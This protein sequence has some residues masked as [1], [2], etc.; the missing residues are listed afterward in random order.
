M[1]H[2]TPE[3]IVLLLLLALTAL[4][5]LLAIVARR[6]AYALRHSEEQYRMVF[7]ANLQPMWVFD[8]ASLRFLAVNTSAIEHYGYS[9]DEFLAMGILDI[10]PPEDAEKVLADIRNSSAELRHAG[11][12]R[13]RVRDG[14]I[15]LA[16]V[17][18]QSLTFNGRSALFVQA[19]DVT[20][21][22]R[23]RQEME[24]QRD[25]LQR[26][27]ELIDLSNDAIITATPDRVITS[28]NVGAEKLY[29]WSKA[30]AV[31]QVLGSLLQTDPQVSDE[32]VA[33]LHEKLRWEGEL[34]QRR[35]DGSTVTVDSRQ[36]LRLDADGAPVGILEI[37]RD[38]STHK[39]LEEQLR[40]AQKL[41]SIGQLAGGVAHDFNNLMTIV[42]GY[43]GMALEDL[44]PVSPLRDSLQ[45]IQEAATRATSL[46]RQLL[47]FS[48]RQIQSAANIDLNEV[49]LG[50]EKI[51]R[52]CIGEDVVLTLALDS[53][54]AMVHADRGHIEQ[55]ILNLAI[56]ARDAMPDGGNLLVE[57]SKVFVDASFA[58]Q[59]LSLKPGSYVLLAVSDTG[60]GMSAEVCRQCFEPFFTTKEAGKGTGLGLSTVYGIVKQSEGAIFVYSEPGCGSA[61]KIFL[62]FIDGGT[63]PV[64]VIEA[65]QLLSGTETILLVEDEDGLRKYVRETLERKGYTVVATG[66]GSEALRFARAEGNTIDLL[67]TDMVMP[68]MG[69]PNWRKHSWQLVRT[70]PYCACPGTATACG[71][72]TGTRI[73]CKSHSRPSCCYL[74]SAGYW[75]MEGTIDKDSSERSSGGRRPSSIEAVFEDSN[76]RRLCGKDREFGREGDRGAGCGWP[77]GPDGAGFEHAGARR[78]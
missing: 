60:M 6:R 27:A 58:E 25:R 77:G 44:P 42:S 26:Q 16:D 43:A 31:G 22:E 67:L 57:A 75:E 5:G 33:I 2:V 76:P 71:E 9:R 38:I 18:G 15:I 68:E 70:C 17:T 46:T 7:E 63:A 37:N 65:P 56:N 35:R 21:R 74:T 23:E 12:W 1:I 47:T 62:P 28:W 8:V 14:R 4:S 78:L 41:D 3:W 52:R 19:T 32:F 39:Q 51:L 49:V 53:V 29:G 10:R 54:P 34:L 36:V 20:L 30:E 59:H 55:V 48:R 40:Q 61:F 72:R 11:V 73:S 64:E 50:M 13:H 66:S 24:R 45:E 69:A